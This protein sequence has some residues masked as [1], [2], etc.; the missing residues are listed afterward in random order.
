MSNCDITIQIIN[1]EPKK[2]TLIPFND[3][4]CIFQ[5]N[6]YGGTINIEQ[7]KFQKINHQINNVKKDLKYTIKIFNFKIMLTLG[8]SDIIIN[9]NIRFKILNRSKYYLPTKKIMLVYVL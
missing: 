4:I 1:Y 2:N 9:V 6:N 8:L 5:I 7:Y 3:L